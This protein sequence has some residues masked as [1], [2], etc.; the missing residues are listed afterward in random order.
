MQWTLWQILTHRQTTL[1][2]QPGHVKLREEKEKLGLINQGKSFSVNFILHSEDKNTC[3]Y[4]LT[5]Q[6]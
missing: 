1:P 3:S 5:G 6:L 4:Y 2:R